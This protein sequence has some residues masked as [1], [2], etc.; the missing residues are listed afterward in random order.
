MTITGF[1][2]PS[3]RVSLRRWGVVWYSLL[4]LGFYNAKNWIRWKNKKNLRQMLRSVW[5]GIRGYK[6]SW[7][8]I[9]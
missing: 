1:N 6:Q 2:F 8:S 7:K 9:S 3:F 5:K 4:F